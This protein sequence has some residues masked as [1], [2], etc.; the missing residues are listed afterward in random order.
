MKVEDG[1]ED[2]RSIR[3]LGG[4]KLTAGVLRS[5]PK[6]EEGLFFAI[7]EG[8]GIFVACFLPGT[9]QRPNV[10][11]LKIFIKSFF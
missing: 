11:L 9:Q 8:S 2:I 1:L 7:G 10:F 6:P 4:E 5:S 3:G